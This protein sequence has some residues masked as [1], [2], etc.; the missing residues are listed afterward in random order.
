MIHLDRFAGLAPAYVYD[1]LLDEGT[2]LGSIPTM[3]RIFRERTWSC[4]RVVAGD[5]T[6][7]FRI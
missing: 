4:G 5:I 2:F 3:H 6:P 7:S 1:T